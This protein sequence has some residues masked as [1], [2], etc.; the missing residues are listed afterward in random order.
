VDDD[1]DDDD[2]DDADI[3]GVDGGDIGCK[4]MSQDPTSSEVMFKDLIVN[5]M[6]VVFVVCVSLRA[7][8][9]FL[10]SCLS[11]FYSGKHSNLHR[12]QVLIKLIF[13]THQATDS[14]NSCKR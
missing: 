10:G 1:D 5:S 11:T 7:L 9:L 2:D 14:D 13:V 3:D 6:S 4:L 12:F 8:R